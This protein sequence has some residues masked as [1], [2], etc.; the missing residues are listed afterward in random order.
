M[1]VWQ[2]MFGSADVKVLK[3]FEGVRGVKR[4]KVHGSVPG[5]YSEWLERGMV[6]RIGE[7]VEQFTEEE[8]EGVRDWN[9]WTH[10]NR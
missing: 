10:G 3:L 9:V 6:A 4:A 5:R 2:A 1:E 7:V 8:R